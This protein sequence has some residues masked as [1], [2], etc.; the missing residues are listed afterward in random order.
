MLTNYEA[1]TTHRTL[2]ALIGVGLALA[3]APTASAAPVSLSPVVVQLQNGLDA[4]PQE[5]AGGPG[6]EQPTSAVIEKD[7]KVHV[8]TVYMS[9]KVSDEYGPWQCKCSST[10]LHAD[11][12][13]TMGASEVQVSFFDNGDRLCNHPKAASD[14][15]RVLFVF[16]SDHDSANVETYASVLDENC[17]VLMDAKQVSTTNGNNNAAAELTFSGT[18]PTGSLFT[19]GYLSATNDDTSMAMGLEVIDLGGGEVEV[20]RTIL[21]GVVSPSNI[22][23]P[24][25]VRHDDEHSIFCA[26]QGNNRPPEDGIRCALLNHQTG[27]VVHSQIIAA[28]QPSQKRYMNQPTITRLDNGNYALRVL[29][30]SGEGKTNNLKGSNKA[31][32]YVI[33]PLAESFLISAHEEGLGNYPTHSSTCAGAYGLEGKRHF[34]VFAAA[35]TGN[36][37]PLVQFFGYGPGGILADAFHNTW[38][39]GWYADSG[40]LANLYGQNPGTNGRDFLRCI[41]DVPNPGFG[42]PNGFYPSVKTFFALPHGGRIPGEPK[43]SG[44]LALVPGHTTLEATPAPPA[45]LKDVEAGPQGEQPAPSEP[46]APGSDPPS[47]SGDE[48]TAV[49]QTTSGGCATAPTHGTGALAPLAALGL[50]ALARRRRQ[51]TT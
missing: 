47:P 25:I 44:W 4:G 41:G 43:N 48:P 38:V 24:T 32:D 11:G 23:R 20:E 22:G 6:F 46:P 1:H 2:T 42:Q 30:S 50:V 49:L 26:A 14:G 45:D 7:G 40:K 10:V 34:G 3:G 37:Q 33:T 16:G 39:A 36:G 12:P 35:V 21:T 29:E 18:T 17:N 5:E 9:S 51:A 13:P 15:E 19:G 27:D 8:V 31:H 28:S